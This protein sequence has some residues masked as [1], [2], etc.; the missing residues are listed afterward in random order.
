MRALAL[1]SAP[2]RAEPADRPALEAVSTV[3]LLKNPEG[4]EEAMGVLQGRKATR[5]VHSRL[6]R[7]DLAT[8]NLTKRALETASA[9][10]QGKDK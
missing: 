9:N 8:D 4:D 10:E 3:Y 1:A 6:Q 5:D 2:V 7:R